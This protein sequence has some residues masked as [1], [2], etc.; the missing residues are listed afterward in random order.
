VSTLPQSDAFAAA[1]VQ[2]A[3]ALAAAANDPADAI[4]LL[5][6]LAG[7][8]PSP[9]PGAGP[10]TALMQNAQDAVASNLRCAAC[11]ALAGATAAYQPISYQDAQAVRVAV[12]GALDAEATRA[13]DAGLDATYQALRTLRAAVALDLGVRGANL[14]WLVEIDTAASMPSLAEAWTLYQDTTREPGLVASA[15]VA[16]PLFMPL[17]FPALNA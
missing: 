7:W 2:L 17:S 8:V 10:V 9:L 11:G 5:L 12:C 13:A 16:H 3:T 4:R 6:P 14:A 1:G 15:D